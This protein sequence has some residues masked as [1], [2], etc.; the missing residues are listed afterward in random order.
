MD[1]A[2]GMKMVVLAALVA[3][4]GCTVQPLYS[5]APTEGLTANAPVLASVAIDEVDTRVAQQV[6]NRLIFLLRGG[7]E[8]SA[9]PQ[10]AAK[11]EVSEREQSVFRVQAP[12]GTTTITARRLTVTGTITLTR[13]ADGVVIAQETRSAAASFDNTRQEFANLRA[14]RD[15]ENRAAAELAEQLRVVV[16]TALVGR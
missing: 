15:A 8:L 13:K 7:A 6:R 12:D 9:S 16:A 4:A 1:I 14:L 2:N 10:Y 3:I 11:L 5:P